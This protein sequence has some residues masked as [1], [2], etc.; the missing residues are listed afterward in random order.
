M[1]TRR[2]HIIGDSCS[3]KTTLAR[4]IAE[5]LGLPH[6]ELDALHHGPNWSQPTAEEFRA[7]VDDVFSRLD[8]W[9]VDGA[10]TGK[11]GKSLIDRADT[12]VWLDLPLN[13]LLRRMW[14]RTRTRIRTQ[15]ELWAPG[16]TESWR[17]FLLERDGL[18]RYTVAN[19]RRR[20][21]RWPVWL[22]G[23]PLVRLRS[24]REIEE[25]LHSEIG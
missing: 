10:Y 11:L 23:R 5:H 16:N 7:K 21:R 4:T 8:G 13:L 22:E 3:G 18:L 15:E 6:V 2:I 24:P 17:S 25:W 12:V 1:T 9:V 19:Y 14:R 20:R